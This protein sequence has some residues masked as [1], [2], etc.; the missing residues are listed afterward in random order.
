MHIGA[1]PVERQR[2]EVELCSV[3]DLLMKLADLLFNLPQL[4]LDLLDPDVG[5]Q[6]PGHGGHSGKHN[7]FRRWPQ[8]GSLARSQLLLEALA[9]VDSLL[10]RVPHRLQLLFAFTLGAAAVW[11]V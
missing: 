9:A 5:L 10:A 8:H 1:H 3:I 6:P 11:K 4:R 7:V 2:L